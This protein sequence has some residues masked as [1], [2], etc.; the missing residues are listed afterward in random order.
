M[1][2]CR[3]EKFNFF[4]YNKSINNRFRIRNKRKEEEEEEILNF[5]TSF[6]KQCNLI[7][8]VPLYTYINARV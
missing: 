4:P 3:I 6:T 8:N 5:E 2:P 1:R 7:I